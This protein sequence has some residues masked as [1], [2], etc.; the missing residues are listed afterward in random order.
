MRGSEASDASRSVRAAPLRGRKPSKVNRSAGSPERATASV[1]A[2][3]PGM[4][5]TAAPT[6]SAARTALSPGSEMVGI[7]ASVS[8]ATVSPASSRP[9]SSAARSASLPAK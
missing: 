2:L 6:P 9:A 8:R 4:P 1:T 3:G 5:V 7:P